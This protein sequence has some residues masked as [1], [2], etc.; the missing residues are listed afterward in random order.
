MERHLLIGYFMGLRPLIDILTR[1][2]RERICWNDCAKRLDLV[3]P[4][5]DKKLAW[6]GGCHD[7]KLMQA[8]LD[9]AFMDNQWMM[10]LNYKLN[11]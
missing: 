1:W 11:I 4:C 9:R 2:I 10:E 3:D 8:R 6:L 5:L 7:G